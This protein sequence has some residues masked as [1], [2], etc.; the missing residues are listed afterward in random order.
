MA[1]P[2][3]V[4]LNNGSTTGPNGVSV[5]SWAPPWATVLTNTRSPAEFAQNK[6]GVGVECTPVS[7]ALAAGLP[8][9]VAAQN[10]QLRGAE[11][12]RAEVLFIGASEA[13]TRTKKQGEAL[14]ISRE[15]PL[16]C[17]PP[18]CAGDRQRGVRAGL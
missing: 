10:H 7:T 17:P 14:A 13:H 18:D 16:F 3:I 15:T 9:A 11:K 5:L 4:I 8:H 12:K 6:Y 2:A 1:G